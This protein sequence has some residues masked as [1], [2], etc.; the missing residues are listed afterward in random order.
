MFVTKR[1]RSQWS[2]LLNLPLYVKHYNVA[3]VGGGSEMGQVA[4]MLLR[5]EPNITKLTIHDTLPYITGTIMDISHIPS[6]PKI[7]GFTG[8]TNLY[9]AIEDADIILATGGICETPGIPNKDIFLTNTTF[10]KNFAKAVSG[11]RQ[12]PFVG[13]A[14]EPINT[15]VPIAAEIMRCSG[16]LA[17]NKLFGI[18]GIDA[19]RA[20]TLYA[21]KCNLN[22]NN[23]TVH[24]IG[25]HSEK[26]M[27]PLLSQAMPLV[28]LDQA[29][30]QEL[31]MKIRSG[32]EIITDAKNGH[33]P[34]LA[35]AY[36]VL[37]FTRA[38][39]RALDGKLT[40]VHAYVENNDFG[41]SFFSGL[42]YVDKNGAGEMARYTNLSEFE[43]D[44]LEESIN[45]LRIAID[46][47]KKVVEVD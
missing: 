31:T 28:N 7:K 29:L 37:L 15:L 26:T 41:T 16:D 36:G 13:I 3:V 21:T 35:N 14:T 19:L 9:K 1:L 24:V 5:G 44:L 32:D 11:L 30:I 25:G 20:Q 42:V 17:L 8:D 22:A 33:G 43:C 12:I 18:T 2:S 6:E 27:V 40:P 38:I 39:L 47:S 34:A 10:I 23:C 45:S 46:S 4:C